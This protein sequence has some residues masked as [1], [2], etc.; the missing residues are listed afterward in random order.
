MGCLLKKMLPLPLG[1]CTGQNTKNHFMGAK[2]IA[3]QLLMGEE[4][5]EKSQVCQQRRNVQNT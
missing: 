5:P 3:E 1:R 4:R 2:G